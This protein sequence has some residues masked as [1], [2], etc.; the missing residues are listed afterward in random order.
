M[1][2]ILILLE[3]VKNLK[4][5]CIY[6]YNY[7]RYISNITYPR[8]HLGTYDYH[9]IITKDITTFDFYLYEGQNGFCSN[10]ILYISFFYLKFEI[11]I[12][13]NY[14]RITW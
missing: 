11:L 7:F 5:F 13:I 9:G 6:I 8:P 2:I 14:D 4:Q 10:C 1:V 3:Q 12:N